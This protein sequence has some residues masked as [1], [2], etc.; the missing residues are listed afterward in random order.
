[1]TASHLPPARRR[2]LLGVD[3]VAPLTPSPSPAEGEGRKIGR[4]RSSSSSPLSPRGRGAGG[5]GASAHSF[6]ITVG[7]L[8]VLCFVVLSPLSN[9]LRAADALWKAGTAKAVITPKERL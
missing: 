7:R 5:E 4:K 8:F 6:W 3:N 1:M 9:W 2:G